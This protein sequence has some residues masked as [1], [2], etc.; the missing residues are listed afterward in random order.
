[1]AVDVYS[2]RVKFHQ[3]KC[4]ICSYRDDFN[5]I[6][7]IEIRDRLITLQEFMK[8]EVSRQKSVLDVTCPSC[9]ARLNLREVDKVTWSRR[10][11]PK[12]V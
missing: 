9:G 1:M 6:L 2:V 5:V 10:S 4:R 8:D 3:V 11:G 12:T 7:K